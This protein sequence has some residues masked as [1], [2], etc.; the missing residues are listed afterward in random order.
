MTG[1][2]IYL[3]KDIKKLLTLVGR[4]F[5]LFIV[6]VFQIYISVSLLLQ[7]FKKEWDFHYLK[8]SKLANKLLTKDLIRSVSIPKINITPPKLPPIHLPS[9]PSVR[10]RFF[11]IKTIV[12]IFTGILL[13]GGIGS[14]A[15]L[16]ILSDVPSAEEFKT[17]KPAVSTK[18]YDRTGN[19]LYTIYKDENRTPVSLDEVPMHVRLATIAVEDSEFYNHHGFSPRGMI[20]S[21]VNYFRTGELAGGSTITQ[22]LVKNALLSSEK[23]ITRKIK[24]LHLAIQTEKILSK[25]EILEMYLNEVSY[26]GPAYGIETAS[27]YYFDKKTRDLSLGEAALLAGLTK[28]PTIFSP[29]GSHPEYAIGRRD[30]VLNLM[31]ANGFITEEMAQTAKEEKISFADNKTNIDAPHF[32]MFVREHLVKMFGEEMVER[33]G[34]SVT[35][36]LDSGIQRLSEEVIRSE[37]EN[38][39]ALNVT[40][41]A[42]VIANPKTGEILAMVGSIDYFDKEQDG[43]VNVALQLRQPGSSIKVINYAYALSH[44]FTPATIIED[45]P[46]TFEVPGQLP[47]RPKNYDGGFRGR[48]TLRSALAESRNIPAVK[49]LNTYGV[50]KMIDLGSQMGITSWSDS[51]RYGLSLTLGGGEVKLID[52]AQAYATL[53]NSGIREDFTPLVKVT[54][55]E[56][57]VLYQNRLDGQQV[58]DPRVAFQIT[59]ILSDNNARTPAFGRFSSLIIPNH[60]EVAV[61]TGT[62][63]DLRDNLTVGYSKDYVVAIWVGNNDNS[64]MS[65]IASGVTGASPIWNKI[66]TGLLAEQPSFAWQTPS[67]LIQVS[68]CTYTGTLACS[69]CP[70]KQEWFIPGTEPTNSCFPFVADNPNDS[71]IEEININR[72]RDRGRGNRSERSI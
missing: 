20:R 8:F 11:P 67:D 45:S 13:I 34:L 49:L 57:K 54:N 9:K 47:Y 72:G 10:L 63:N 41:G 16:S 68:V 1:F 2:L 40:N 18:I 59:D 28:S 69:G 7:D 55:Q 53:A 37:V 46:A 43:N 56:G 61:K 26:G 27:K 60:P 5:Y 65:R 48:I 4:P 44:G 24:E 42:A 19:L 52:L 35:T 70:T 36:T 3:L 12:I 71:N 66:M 64:P 58:L 6:F 32:V 14:L 62:S 50:Q 51:S 17:R 23:T 21:A 39:K 31:V 22:Q 33:G 29:F 38:L 30:E 25:D 15:L